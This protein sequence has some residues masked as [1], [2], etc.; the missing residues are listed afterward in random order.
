MP[1][2]KKKWLS[3]EEFEKIQADKAAAAKEAQDTENAQHGAE[4]MR[5]VGQSGLVPLAP[6]P[7]GGAK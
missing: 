3:W 2:P 1:T 4:A 5:N 7:E 6:Q